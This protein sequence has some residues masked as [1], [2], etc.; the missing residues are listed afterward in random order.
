MF[1]QKNRSGT[2]ITQ[3]LLEEQHKKQMTVELFK[4]LLTSITCMTL[5]SNF[6]THKKIIKLNDKKLGFDGKK[7]FAWNILVSQIS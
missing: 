2:I 4:I 6:K 5:F 1:G 7:C 3:S